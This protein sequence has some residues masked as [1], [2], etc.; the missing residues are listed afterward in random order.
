M[1]DSAKPTQAV[2][3]TLAA[4]A[5]NSLNK[6]LAGKLNVPMSDIEIPDPSCNTIGRSYD[7]FMTQTT[8]LLV[9]LLERKPNPFALSHEVD[10]GWDIFPEIKWTQALWA[11]R[12]AVS[13]LPL[14]L[15]CYWQRNLTR[16]KANAYPGLEGQ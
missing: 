10:D 2:E 7:D 11:S 16:Q 5:I 8:R 9:L 4:I 12:G 13:F 3:K 15:K 6:D 14:F 1:V